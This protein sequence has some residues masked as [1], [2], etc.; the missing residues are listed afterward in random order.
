MSSAPPG[1]IPDVLLPTYMAKSLG[2]MKVPR[3]F[4]R[5]TFNNSEASPG[6]TLYV[7]V[8][9]MNENE[10]LVPGSLALR[11]D[12]ELD[13]GHVQNVT[14]ALVDQLVVKFAVKKRW[15][16][17]STKRSKTCSSR[18]KNATTWCRRGFRV[19]TCARYVQ[20]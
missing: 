20:T 4:K 6:E 13:G 17:A 10:V 2:A 12:I 8:P 7:S 3:S 16:T 11:F 19:K 5:I 14:R 1:E 15:G 18:S 9:K